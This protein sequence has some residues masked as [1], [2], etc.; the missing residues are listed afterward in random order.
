MESS[1]TV[2]NVHA[3]ITSIK[4]QIISQYAPAKIILFGSHVKGTAT[5]KSDID[6]CVVKN[7]NN[8]RELLTEMYLNIES[9]KPFDLVLYT[10]P[11]W[12]ECVND[13]TSFAYIINKKGIVLYD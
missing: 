11:E 6:L 13:T 7:T 3:Q 1:Y 10:E 12:E 8:K 9:D 2:V 5:P 4:E